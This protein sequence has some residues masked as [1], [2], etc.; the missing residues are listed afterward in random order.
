MRGSLL[1]SVLI[2]AGSAVHPTTQAPAAVRLVLAPTGNEARY[3][4]REQLA[5]VSFPTDA[6]GSTTTLTGTLVLDAH[7]MIV[8][9]E[10]KF[11]VDLTT[12]KS[13]RERRDRFIQGRTLETAQFPSAHLVPTDLTGLP[14]PLPASGDFTFTLTGDLTVHGVTRPTTWQVA[15]AAKDGGFS[16]TASTHVTFADFG[17]TPPRVMVVLSVADTI[18]LEYDFR[19]VP[20][21]AGGR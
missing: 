7:G 1:A 20:D 19:F 10:S 12:L 4:V 9:G 3:R 16:G 18:G 6:V 13:D 15:A 11:T 14:W 21:T 17:M 8:P 5:N 2:L